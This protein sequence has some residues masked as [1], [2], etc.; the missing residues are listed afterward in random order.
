[1]S[2][3]NTH[4]NDAAFAAALNAT[5]PAQVLFG[6]ILLD[7]WFCALIKGQGRVPF[8]PGMHTQSQRRT[9]VNISITPIPESGLTYTVDRQF[10]AENTRDGW[11]AVTLPSLQKIGVNDLRVL[12]GKY[13]KAELRNYGTYNKRDGSVGELS[14]PVIYAVYNTAAECAAAYDAEMNGMAA[15]DAIAPT[16]PRAVPSTNGG[17]NGNGAKPPVAAAPQPNGDAE[18][19]TALAFLPAI[20]KSCMNGSGVD[21]TKLRTSIESNALLSR[22]ISLTSPEV[23]AEV[24]RIA[25]LAT[26]EVPF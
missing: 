15:F 10:I 14:A 13:V 22:H 11:L 17:S 12:S 6:E 2:L 3:I 1:M 4:D 7:I 23:M 18:R 25:S 20:V 16:A 24:T 26:A 21:M 9:S 5:A 19:Q 8:D